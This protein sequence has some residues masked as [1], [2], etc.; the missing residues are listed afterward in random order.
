MH[1]N[2]PYDRKD[3]ISIEKY[4][5]GLVNKSIRQLYGKEIENAYSGKGK[6]GQLVE[7]LYFGYK[8]NSNPEPDFPEAG[9]ELKTTPIKKNSK[10][11]VSKERLVFNIIDFETEYKLSFKESSFWKKNSL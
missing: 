10:G 7:F 5:K 8:P 11:F 6:L 1:K 9:V 3:P 2:F 4:S